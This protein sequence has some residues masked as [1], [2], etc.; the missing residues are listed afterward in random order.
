[1]A[2]NVLLAIDNIYRLTIGR[3]GCVKFDVVYW[4][5]G[6]LIV[7]CKEV[8]MSHRNYIGFDY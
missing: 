7:L 8:L 3:I 6:R 5:Q 1:M 2:C 4:Q